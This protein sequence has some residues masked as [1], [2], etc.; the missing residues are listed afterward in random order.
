V[1]SN[2]GGP[3]ESM[4]KF[5]FLGGGEPKATDQGTTSIANQGK[6]CLVGKLTADR[7][8][9]KD[10]IKSTLM[11]ELETHKDNCVQGVGREHF[12]GGVQTCVG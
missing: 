3:L 4:T 6:S 11:Q 9:G 12:F 7:I 8:I 2:S 10:A 5:F 1:V